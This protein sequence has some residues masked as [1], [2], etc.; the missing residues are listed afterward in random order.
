MTTLRTFIIL[1]R[2]PEARE[3]VQKLSEQEALKILEKNSYF[4]PH[5]LVRNEHK[6]KLRSRFF[7]ALLQRTEVFQVN[8]VQ[9][10]EQSQEIIGKLAKG[11]L[12]QEER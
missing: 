7:E 5:L 4:N 2:D 3:F 9:T 12:R 11:D 6:Q 1:K 10:P 8:T